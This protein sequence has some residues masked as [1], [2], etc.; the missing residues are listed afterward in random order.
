VGLDD[1]RLDGGAWA[2]AEALGRELGVTALFPELP[3]ARPTGQPQPQPQPE[4][5]PSPRAGKSLGP[6]ASWKVETSGAVIT[7][8]T[9]AGERTNPAVVLTNPSW[10]DPDPP[11]DLVAEHRAE[12]RAVKTVKELVAHVRTVAAKERA[13]LD[14]GAAKVAYKNARY[15]IQDARRLAWFEA[16]AAAA[17]E[18]PLP[19]ADRARVP[20]VLAAEKERL[21]CDRDY[22]M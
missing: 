13:Y 21:I 5:Q 9:R 19:A 22:D 12:L 1:V 8:E 18:L 2:A 11:R 3:N 17:Q 15:G 4:P 20:A 6:M 10:K 16:L 7:F 14:A